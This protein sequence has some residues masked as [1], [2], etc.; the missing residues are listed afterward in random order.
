MIYR[1]ME[2]EEIHR[3]LFDAF[4]RRQVVTK[5]RR[6]EDA[7]W[8]VRD[9]PFIDD[10]NE[11]DYSELLEELRCIQKCGGVVYG[12]YDSGT[13]KGFAAVDGRAFGVDH[14]YLDLVFL[15]VSADA[16]GRGVGRTLFGMAAGW[17]ASRGARKLYLSAH[18]AVETQAFYSAMGCVEAEE[19]SSAHVEK[20]PFDCQM[21]YVL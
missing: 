5:C 21:E 1:Q 2:T 18:S 11:E 17:A 8:V 10:W 6:K 4:I 3:S 12:A 9:D 20:E 15:H 13:L 16:R 7:G 19:Y 14:A